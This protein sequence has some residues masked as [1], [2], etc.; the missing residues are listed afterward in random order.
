[1]EDQIVALQHAATALVAQARALAASVETARAEANIRTQQEAEQARAE[2]RQE[3]E[4]ECKRRRAETERQCQERL[5]AAEER[6]AWLT[7]EVAAMEELHM[8]QDSVV[9]LSVGGRHFT[10]SVHTL[11]SIPGSML[12]SM[13]SGRFA[14][15]KTEDQRV[16]ID[17]DGAMFE[18]VLRYLRDRVVEVEGLDRTSLRRLQ[19]EFAFYGIAVEPVPGG[20]GAVVVGGCADFHANMQSVE[21]YDPVADRWEFVAPLM[22]ARQGHACVSL[23]DKVLTIGG[24][25]DYTPLRDVM[26]L[27]LSTGTW[28]ALAP[29]STARRLH[30]ASVVGGKVYVAGGDNNRFLDS[31]EVFDPASNSWSAGPALP[32]VLSNFGMCAVGN[33]IYVVGGSTR[34]QCGSSSVY[35]WDV[36]SGEGWRTVAPL[37]RGRY[38]CA[39]AAF[40]GKVFVFGGRDNQGERLDAVEQFDPEVDRWTAMAPMS[41]G[42]SCLCCFVLGERIVV[43]GGNAESFAVSSVEAFDPV[44]NSWTSV[45]SLQS[46]RYNAGAA[47][48]QGESTCLFE[49]ALA[50]M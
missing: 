40:Q 41:A 2:A 32:V 34:N 29:L 22:P 9:K 7:R 39:V 33:T 12:D 25:H 30:G 42:K 16:F 45:S 15:K 3:V 49:R 14:V 17:R 38:H 23:G 26:Q 48:V 19:R 20:Q 18:P 31:V 44:A 21:R 36:S 37:Q 27:D 1:M 13:F 24:S 10:T 46:G 8:I 50:T 35:K 11:R 28:Q 47:M 4:V 5:Q 6:H 43:A